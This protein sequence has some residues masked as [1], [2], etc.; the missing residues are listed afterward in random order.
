MVMSFLI[1]FCNS[2]HKRWSAFPHFLIVDSAGDLLLIP[3]RFRLK[4]SPF[5]ACP[6]VFLQLPGEEHAQTSLPIRV[7]GQILGGCPHAIHR[8]SSRVK[9]DL[10][11]QTSGKSSA[12]EDRHVSYLLWDWSFK[13]TIPCIIFW[14]T[15]WCRVDWA[16]LRPDCSQIIPHSFFALPLCYRGA[17]S[18]RLHFPGTQVWLLDGSDG[19]DL[20]GRLR[21]M[22]KGDASAL[23]L[24]LHCRRPWWR[25]PPVMP[26]PSSGPG[27]QGH[28]FLPGPCDLGLV[29]PSYTSGGLSVPSGLSVPCVP[30]PCNDTSSPFPL[31]CWQNLFYWCRAVCWAFALLSFFFHLVL[32]LITKTFPITSYRDHFIHCSVWLPISYLSPQQW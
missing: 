31:A 10:N 26:A 32:S 4:W 22:K 9:P 16:S 14:P 23:W 8:L 20:V 3:S 15:N 13:K 6:L 7:K 24:L 30:Y 2:S 29:I 17:G 18:C 28:S 21:N 27:H 25:S 11:G 12:L 19:E 5:S 1:Q